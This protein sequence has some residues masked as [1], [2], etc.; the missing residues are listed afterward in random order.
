MLRRICEWAQHGFG[1][2]KKSGV[3]IAEIAL[4]RTAVAVVEDGT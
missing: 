3:D 1:E 4:V 2:F